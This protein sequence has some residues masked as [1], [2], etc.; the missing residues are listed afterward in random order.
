MRQSHALSSSYGGGGGRTRWSAP[1]FGFALGSVDEGGP[2]ANGLGGRVPGDDGEMEHDGDGAGSARA[3][4]APGRGGSHLSSGMGNRKR[5][6]DSF[7]DPADWDP[8]FS[9][10]LLLDDHGGAGAGGAD[11]HAAQASRRRR[12]P[13]P[14]P[15][16]SAPPPSGAS[17]T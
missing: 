13:P 16:R 10:E 4:R 15:R 7:N 17:L 14:R 6:Q 11:G 3:H 1:R 2:N 9:D 5:S 12:A 8:N